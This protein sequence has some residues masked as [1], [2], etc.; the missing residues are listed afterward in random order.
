MSMQARSPRNSSA[1]SFIN[2]WSASDSSSGVGAGCG[3]AIGVGAEGM[4]SDTGAGVGGGA[5]G[6]AA[7]GDDTAAPEAEEDASAVGTAWAARA[8]A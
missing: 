5:S 2:C 4:T 1:A 8:V 6:A 3:A 7:R